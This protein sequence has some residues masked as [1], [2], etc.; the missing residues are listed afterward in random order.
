MQAMFEKNHGIRISLT[1]VLVLVFV[2]FIFFYFVYTITKGKQPQNIS[3]FYIYNFLKYVEYHECRL[4]KQKNQNTLALKI[5][6][7]ANFPTLFQFKY[8][9]LCI[10]IQAAV[11][12]QKFKIPDQKKK[13]KK[14]FCKFENLFF[15]F[16][17]LHS[18]YSTY[19]KKL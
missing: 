3:K 1:Y 5:A 6:C 19:F 2:F 16:P 7:W 11:W 8:Y 12:K 10:H 4:G 9:L 17:N 13:K 14:Q 18:W 15:F